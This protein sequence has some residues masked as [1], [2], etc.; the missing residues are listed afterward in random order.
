MKVNTQVLVPP[1]Y[2]EKTWFVLQWAITFRNSH[3]RIQCNRNSPNKFRLWLFFGS[4]RFSYNTLLNPILL[5]IIVT[6]YA[7]F[8][9][10][11][12][13]VPPS[14]QKFPGP[15]YRLFI[16]RIVLFCIPVR[17]VTTVGV[18]LQNL[19]YVLI[20]LLNRHRYVFHAQSAPCISLVNALDGSQ[21]LKLSPLLTDV[22]I[23]ELG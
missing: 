22:S 12:V 17:L 15:R 19:N 16:P 4:Q 10:C 6:D 7:F 3:N 1:L 11:Y 2:L 8:S 18:R 9:V 5:P 23:T 21:H 20:W 14:S 13:R